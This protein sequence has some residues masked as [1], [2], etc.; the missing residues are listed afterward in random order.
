MS[1]LYIPVAKLSLN[2]LLWKSS[3][4]VIL[5]VIIVSTTDLAKSVTG[6]ANMSPFILNISKLAI[7]LFCD[8]R[9]VL[10]LE[11]LSVLSEPF[12]LSFT[13]CK[14]GFRRARILFLL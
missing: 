13:P 12:N 1:V 8:I 9:P 11:F 6:L 7:L 10:V 14:L 5:V 2:L 3:D 4:D